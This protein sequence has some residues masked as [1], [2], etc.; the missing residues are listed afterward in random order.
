MRKCYFCH[1]WISS[2]IIT[3]PECNTVIGISKKMRKY[4]KRQKKLRFAV[5]ARNIDISKSFRDYYKNKPKEV[6]L[7]KLKYLAEYK[8]KNPQKY[9]KRRKK[10]WGIPRA[11]C[12]VCKINKADY[13]HHIILIINGGIP[14]ISNTIP[15]CKYCHEKIHPWLKKAVMVE[16]KEN[17]LFTRGGFINREEESNDLIKTAAFPAIHNE[18][19]SSPN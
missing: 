4:A 15:I 2:L 14:D 18:L 12:F 16:R 1:E 8:L 10:K 6:I 13:Y 5:A 7:T 3:C 17:K 19:V 11:N 9:P